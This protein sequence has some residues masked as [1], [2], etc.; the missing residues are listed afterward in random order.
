MQD[1][2]PLI[3]L[4][5]TR[6]ELTYRVNEI[7]YTCLDTLYIAI[8]CNETRCTTNYPVGNSFREF[9]KNNGFAVKESI[10]SEFNI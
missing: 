10:A 6:G 7:Y 1:S 8:I 9:L 4:D 3:G 2:L 5:L